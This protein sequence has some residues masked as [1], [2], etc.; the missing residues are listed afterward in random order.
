MKPEIEVG[1]HLKTWSIRQLRDA[2]NQ[3]LFMCHTE[4]ERL[5]VRAICGKEIREHAEQFS[6]TRK[7]TPGEI[8]IAQEFGYRGR[9]TQ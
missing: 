7:L 1:A 5:M 2:M 8:A 4:H 3:D 6:K 9:T